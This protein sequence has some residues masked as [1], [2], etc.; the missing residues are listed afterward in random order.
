M[1]WAYMCVVAQ[2]E[3]DGVR[4]VRVCGCSGSCVCTCVAVRYD[5]AAEFHTAEEAQSPP[6]REHPY[7]KPFPQSPLLWNH[8][9]ISEMVWVSLVQTWGGHGTAS[10]GPSWWSSQKKAGG[11]QMLY[12]G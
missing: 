11:L 9:C 5:L 12:P 4:H 3:G 1:N 6:S 8:I 7:L 2:M 10:A